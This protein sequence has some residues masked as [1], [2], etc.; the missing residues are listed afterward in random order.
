MGKK[1]REDAERALKKAR[2]DAE[3]AERRAR[4]DAERRFASQKTAQKK[5]LCETPDVSYES[6]FPALMAVQSKIVEKTR[7]DAQRALKKSREDAKQMERRARVQAELRQAD[8][9]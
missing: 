7:D 5:K 6:N 4:V 8:A 1:A 9:E 2:E 3:R